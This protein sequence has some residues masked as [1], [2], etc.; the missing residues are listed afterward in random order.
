MGEELGQ[1]EQHAGHQR[2]FE[3][4]VAEDDQRAGGRAAAGAFV[5]RHRQERPGHHRAGEPDDEG[6]AEDAREIQ[7]GVHDSEWA[8]CAQRVPVTADN[9]AW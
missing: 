8:P 4:G 1:P 3:H 5:D 7:E 2:R 6:E 9:A